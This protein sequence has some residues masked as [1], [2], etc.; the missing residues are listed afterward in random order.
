M[1]AGDHNGVPT[2]QVRFA[3]NFALNL[4]SIEAFWIES[5]FA[6]GHDR[7]LDALTDVQIPNLQ[8]YPRMGRPFMSRVA[9][10]VEAQRLLASIRSE[11]WCSCW[12]SSI[13]GG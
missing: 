1:P 4:E 11:T 2:A 9:E 5:E 13:S 10:S 7:L 12:R 6:Q 3:A 8:R